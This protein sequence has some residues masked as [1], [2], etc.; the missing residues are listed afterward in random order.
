[1]AK[2]SAGV[3]QLIVVCQEV[4]LGVGQGVVHRYPRTNH[5]GKILSIV[6]KYSQG[7]DIANMHQA[8]SELDHWS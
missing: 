4:G 8:A 7:M 5:I 2:M 1:M 3:Y 6:F